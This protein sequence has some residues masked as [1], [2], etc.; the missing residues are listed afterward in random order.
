VPW[1]NGGGG[2]ARSD[3]QREVGSE[4]IVG[5]RG[6]LFEVPLGKGDLF[7]GRGLARLPG[8]HLRGGGP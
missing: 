6:A 4:K 2:T 1:V 8:K 3:V 7:V 5:A